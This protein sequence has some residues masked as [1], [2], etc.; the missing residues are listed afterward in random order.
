MAAR[1]KVLMSA[2]ACRPGKGSEH[3]IGWQ[4][5]LHMARIHDVT[6]L[7]RRKSREAIE[8]ELKRL[9]DAHPVPTFEY[10]E[11]N[12]LMLGL[13]ARVSSFVRVYYVAW[14]RSVRRRISALVRRN[15]Y[16][17]LHHVT[18]SAY[19]YPTAI[20]GHGIPCIWGPIGG[21]IAIAAVPEHHLLAPLRDH[22]KGRLGDAVERFRRGRGAM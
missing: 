9:G 4:W 3:E 17:L 12:R 2:Y 19:R 16:D 6:V 7:T 20:W 8:K 14:Q 22:A 11:C 15:H 18:F 5:T 1:L 21:V 13:K 10:H